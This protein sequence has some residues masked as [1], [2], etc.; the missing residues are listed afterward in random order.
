MLSNLILHQ[1][2]TS[3]TL[4]AARPRPIVEIVLFTLVTAIAHKAF[5]AFATAIIFTL[6]QKGSLVV[7]ITRFAAF[8]AKPEVVG[9]TALAVLTGDARL[10]LT[11]S[12]ADVTLPIRG[13]QSMAVTPLTALPA[14]Q[15]VEARVT[16]ATVPARHM[17]QTLALSSHWVTAALLLYCP[18]GIAGTG[19]A[20]VCWIGSQGISKKPFLAPVAVEAS[21]VVDALQAFARQAVAVAN[22]VGVYVVVTLTRAAQP[23]GPIAAQRVSK[24]AVITE[25]TSLAGS[26]SRTVRTHHFL[27]LWDNGTT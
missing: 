17:R 18:I 14:L 25:L 21:R 3:W 13:S 4:L 12:R 5:P 15:V 24:V 7:T 9:L 11:L 16:S 10:A 8:R 2:V 1:P 20:F 27:C 6:E 26:A 19:F 22:R 23:H